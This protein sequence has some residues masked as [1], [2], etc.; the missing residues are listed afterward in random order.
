MCSDTGLK[1]IVVRNVVNAA[2]IATTEATAVLA[3]DKVF[4]EKV[5]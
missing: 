4:A 3:V 1:H 2:V 5:V